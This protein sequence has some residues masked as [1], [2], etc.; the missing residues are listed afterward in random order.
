METRNVVLEERWVD[1]MD[2]LPAA[3]REFG[4][5]RIV[6]QGFDP[7]RGMVLIAGIPRDALNGKPVEATVPQQR[8]VIDV[9]CVERSPH[10]NTVL[11]DADEEFGELQRILRRIAQA[12]ASVL[13]TEQRS[14]LLLA[15][16]A[17][18]RSTWME[19]GG[20]FQQVHINTRAVGAVR[21]FGS[22]LLAARGSDLF[23]MDSHDFRKQWVPVEIRN[24]DAREQLEDIQFVSRMH[25]GRVA[26][27][28]SRRIVALEVATL[29][30]RASIARILASRRGR[31][32]VVLRYVGRLGGDGAIVA[33]VA[34]D[35]MRPFTP[36]INLWPADLDPIAE[37]TAA[38]ST[39]EMARRPAVVAA[40]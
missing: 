27:T 19:R 35:P 36:T 15:S 25:D 4:V 1:D 22:G 5:D 7:T 2:A 28:T 37:V 39:T 30:A 32:G 24:G 10:D 17:Q 9:G 16:S 21:F 29:S 20:V 3:L 18:K 40:S 13:E 26:V 34:V 23:V 33:T 31:K 11:V 8:S 38:L 12:T 14:T 6:R